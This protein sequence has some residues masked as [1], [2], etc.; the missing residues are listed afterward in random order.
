MEDGIVMEQGRTPSAV[1]YTEATL[2]SRR[3]SDNTDRMDT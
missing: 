1:G 3:E 2:T